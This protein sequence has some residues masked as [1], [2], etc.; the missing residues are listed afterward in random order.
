MAD[1]DNITELDS[2]VLAHHLVHLDFEFLTSITG[3]DGA[4]RVSTSLALD[5]DGFSLEKVEFFEL[6]I[7]DNDSA[8]ITIFVII[9]DEAVWCSLWF[10]LLA[11][12]F[13]RERKVNE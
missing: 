1:G 6:L 10:S 7:V 8:I 11:G 3:G 4:D 2:K 5:E 12:F 13:Y 9:H